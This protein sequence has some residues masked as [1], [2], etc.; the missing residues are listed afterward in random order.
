MDDLRIAQQRLKNQRL[1]L[2]FVKN[3][4]VVF[5]TNTEGLSGFLRAI[6]QLNNELSRAS[7]AD[8]TI[9]K[10]AAL[11]CAYSNVT[12]AFA[13]TLSKKGAEI[14]RT[15]NISFEFENLV[16][17][18]LNSEKT[19]NCPLEELVENITKPIVA[20]ARIR[21]YCGH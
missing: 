9:G 18:I 6:E 19:S 17:A 5:E 13:T 1:S 11:L 7:V 20:Y 4:K 8:R 14:L 15:F 21:E 10:A 2:V 12:A 16:P 3:S